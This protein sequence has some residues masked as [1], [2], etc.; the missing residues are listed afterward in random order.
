MAKPAWQTLQTGVALF[1][2]YTDISEPMK[3]FVP[4]FSFNQGATIPGC[5][6]LF[7]PRGTTADMF[8]IGRAYRVEYT[9]ENREVTRV[10]GAVDVDGNLVN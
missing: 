2:G 8:T 7:A 3:F 4:I 9:R 10:I 6:V 5:V 1:K